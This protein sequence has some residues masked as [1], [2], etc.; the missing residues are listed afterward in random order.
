MEKLHFNYGYPKEVMQ[1][2]Y[3]NM[4]VCIN[5]GIWDIH[6]G[7]ILRLDEGRRITHAVRGFKALSRK[8]IRQIY[9][10]PSVYMHLKWPD[11]NRCLEQ[12]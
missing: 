1:F 2:D 7:T 10:E 8:E 3:Q 12:D 11:T 9:G 4:S 5:N 6:N